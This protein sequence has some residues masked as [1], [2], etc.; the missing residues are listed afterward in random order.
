MNF[1][2]HI[3]V[4]V[5]TSQE[6]LFLGVFVWLWLNLCDPTASVLSLPHAQ[7]HPQAERHMVYNILGHILAR[8]TD[9]IAHVP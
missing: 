4:F 6:N 7:A 8:H 9:G 5:F 1:L 2:A 3:A